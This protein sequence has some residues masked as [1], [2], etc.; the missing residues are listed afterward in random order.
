MTIIFY[1]IPSTLPGNA[2]SPN[3]WKARYCLNFK[4]I[5]YRTEWLEYP[6]IAGHCKK[7]GIAPTSVNA[8]GSPK[9][10][11]PAI[12]DP[13]TGVYLADSFAIAEYLEKTYPDTPRLF[14]GNSAGLQATI[15]A[16][17]HPRSAAFFR[18]AREIDFGMPLDDVLPKGDEAVTEWAKFRD[19]LGKVD[20]WYAKSGGPFLMGSAVSW[21]DFAV[22]GSLVWMRTVWGKES[23]E[24]KDIASWQGGRWKM[25]F[26]NLTQY[27]TVA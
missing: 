4:G 20:A 19:D 13:S 7:F 8:D 9:Y 17:L 5:P 16:A 21:A 2:W 22:A 25:L 14:P 24:W 12:H 1:D 3:T 10:T 27:E 18:S 15:D 6:D 23:T 26:E 11:L